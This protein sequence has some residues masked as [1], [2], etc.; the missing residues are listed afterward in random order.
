M[1]AAGY[2]SHEGSEGRPG[3]LLRLLGILL[4]LVAALVV[5]DVARAEIV[6]SSD[7]QGRPITFDVRS[8]GANVEWYAGVLRSAAHGDEISTVT[9]RI[10]PRVELPFYC[11]RSAT[12]CYGTRGGGAV[13]TVPAGEG[14]SV[15]HT[16][17]HEYAHH[18]DQAWPVA[19]HPELN[20]TP[21]WWAA[22]QMESLLGRRLVAFDY[23][24]GWDRSIAEIF[25]EDY[26]YLHA[27]GRYQISWL[28]P[29][30][31]SLRSAL[32]AELGFTPPAQP[33][34]APQ[35]TPQPAPQPLVVV[36]RGTLAPSERREL[37]FTLLGPGR[38]VSLTATIGS[39]RAGARVTVEI[40]CDG[41][42]VATATLTSAQRS[43]TL[44]RAGL[45]PARCR[46]A[47]SSSS[48]SFQ[49]F[50]VVLRLAV[51]QA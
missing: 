23:S 19:G 29:P 27:G 3:L 42:V 25:A 5:A 32:F 22:R 39:R 44:G 28:S 15:A 12:A 51:E 48:T 47:L 38:R 7:A 36:R 46:A 11:G 8:P 1:Q 13:I 4:V 40:A 26:A 43:T 37:P 30:D 35:P 17:L 9:I 33:A 6:T 2:S 50:V 14:D 18:L 49:R 21:A 34:P 45:G 20:G 41:A 24:L 16:L 10:V 31:E